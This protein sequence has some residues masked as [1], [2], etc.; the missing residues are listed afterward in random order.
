ML[1]LHSRPT[2]LPAETHVRTHI[3]M[4]AHACAHIFGYKYAPHTHTLDTHIHTSMQMLSHDVRHRA[5]LPVI[6][7]MMYGQILGCDIS[8]MLWGIMISTEMDVGCDI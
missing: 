8:D 4:C 5:K 2:E 7:W 6:M 3:P 1:D